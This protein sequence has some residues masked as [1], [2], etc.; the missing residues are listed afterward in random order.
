MRGSLI[1]VKDRCAGS[2]GDGDLDMCGAEG[3]IGVSSM[4]IGFVGSAETGRSIVMIL[5]SLVSP[6]LAYNGDQKLAIKI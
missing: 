5:T 4:A 1:G 6:N 2:D 3:I